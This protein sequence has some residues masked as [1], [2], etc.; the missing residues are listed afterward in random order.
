M[1]K[2]TIHMKGFIQK[3][4]FI[5]GGTAGD[6]LDGQVV[7]DMEADG[8]RTND[9]HADMKLVVGGTYEVDS[10]E[11]AR[12]VG[13]RGPFDHARFSE[14]VGKYVTNA[15]GREGWAVRLGP[16]AGVTM[17]NCFYARAETGSFEASSD[18]A[19]W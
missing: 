13:Y 9:C 8:R 14:L 2:I 7:F 18:G 1:A 17:I 12:P 19:A 11:V 16:G 5:R 6:E 3:S 4:H 15:V 10:I